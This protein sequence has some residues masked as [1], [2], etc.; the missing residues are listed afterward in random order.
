MDNLCYFFWINPIQAFGYGS[1]GKHG[2]FRTGTEKIRKLY[3]FCVS[4]RMTQPRLFNRERLV[5]SLNLKPQLEQKRS[6]G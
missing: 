6:E 4:K 2:G 5:Q 3:E 1:Y